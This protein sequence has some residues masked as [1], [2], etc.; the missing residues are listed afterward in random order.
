MI[1][2]KRVQ[3]SKPTRLMRF[4]GV[5]G[6]PYF[7]DEDELVDGICRGCRE[8]QK[9]MSCREVHERRKVKVNT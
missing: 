8:G 3:P 7:L 5:C 2:R 6:F 1:P 4:C 9:G